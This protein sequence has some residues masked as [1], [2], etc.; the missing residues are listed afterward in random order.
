MT[1]NKL[2]Q[3]LINPKLLYKKISRRIGYK[4]Q[5]IKMRFNV[6]FDLDLGDIPLDYK[7]DQ[8][9]HLIAKPGNPFFFEQ[10]NFLSSIDT[11]HDLENV[12]KHK[13]K[14]FSEEYFF[15]NIKCPINLE[16]IAEIASEMPAQ[17]VHKYAPI[18]WH[19]DYKSGYRWDDQLLYLDVPLSP[20]AGV[21]IKVPRE[22]S[23][24]QHIGEMFFADKEVSANEFFLQLIDWI[25]ANPIRRGVNWACTMDVAIRAVNWIWGIRAFENELSKYPKVEAAISKSLMEHGRH[26]YSNLEYYEEC[27]GNHYLSN[28]A[29]LIYISARIPDY[30][31]SD[32]WLLFGIQE[33]IS[34]MNRQVYY[35]G[36]SH[37]ASTNYH[38]LVTEIF[39]ST[40]V[41]VE[42]IPEQRRLEL[43]KVK[44]EKYS[45]KPKLKSAEKNDINLNLVGAIL[46]PAFYKKLQLMVE[47]TSALTKPNGLVPQ[48]GDNDSARL[49]KLM[50]DQGKDIRD[51][52]HILALGGELFND[53]VLR[54][55]GFQS[56]FEANVIA[57]DFVNKDL[58]LSSRSSKKE[59][60]FDDAGIAI[61]SNHNAWLCVTC[62]SNGQNQRGGHGHNDKNSFELN[63][64]GQ[65]YIV[66]GGC[67]FYTSNPKMRNKY[68]STFAHST[69]AVSGKEQDE[70]QKGSAGLFVLDQT[71]NPKLKMDDAGTIKG[72]HD[73]YGEKHTRTLSLSL[74]KLEIHD[75]CA[76]GDSKYLLFNL[77][78]KVSVEDISIGKSEITAVLCHENG[79]KIFVL[80]KGVEGPELID[81]YFGEG[82]GRPIAN[83]ILRVSMPSYSAKTVFSW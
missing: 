62:G 27:T 13:F 18:D 19:C 40:S 3:L 72:V 54:Q 6:L 71:C 24:F 39:L 5:Y 81:G 32:E 64:A 35:D 12:L 37:E 4:Y 10:P 66:D 57:G 31:D 25:T 30:K 36:F 53:A 11:V 21:D 77:D 68:R 45:V 78:P 9:S 55:D 67:P 51:H 82:F 44:I 76:V 47:C 49:H 74:G 63:V 52:S 7:L 23:R 17:M 58:N 61:L 79:G 73:G 50:P 80:L 41:L 65:D 29:G 16:A 28:I 2:V 20:I 56:S 8:S 69:L 42:R 38:R 43:Q 83:K 48:I 26:I 75:Y 60:F 22:M 70:W 33:L 34:E 15:V 14:I 59:R 46:P 1:I